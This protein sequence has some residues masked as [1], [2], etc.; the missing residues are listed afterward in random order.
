MARPRQNIA[1]TNRA[2]R[3]FM[4]DSTNVSTND[5]THEMIAQRVESIGHG[6]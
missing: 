6:R 4:N 1:K 2:R 5:I 3:L